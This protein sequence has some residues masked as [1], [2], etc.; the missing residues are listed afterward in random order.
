MGG[1]IQDAITR[2]IREPVG[3]GDSQLPEIQLRDAEGSPLDAVTLEEFGDDVEHCRRF[4]IQRRNI[5][6]LVE[7][8]ADHAR[9]DDLDELEARFNDAVHWGED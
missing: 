9:E 4:T 2:T 1:Q 7:A 8:L 3:E 6:V 5:P